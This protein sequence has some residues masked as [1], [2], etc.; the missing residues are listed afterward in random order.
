MINYYLVDLYKNFNVI[1]TNGRKIIFAT[2]TKLPIRIQESQN[3]SGS[4][5]NR[6]RIQSEPLIYIDLG[7]R[8]VVLL[9][10]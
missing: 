5:Q 10:D 4:K 6:I 2:L 3:Q 7:E 9:D 8:E 1:C